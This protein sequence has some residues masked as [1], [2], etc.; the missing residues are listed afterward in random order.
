MHRSLI[1]L[2]PHILDWDLKDGSCEN[3]I[4]II[5][6]DDWDMPPMNMDVGLED[7]KRKWEIPEPRHVG[8]DV[9]SSDQPV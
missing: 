1:R 7:P 4:K 8:F 3:S 9:Y 6:D 5:D 2:K